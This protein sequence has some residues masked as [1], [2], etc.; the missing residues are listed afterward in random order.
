MAIVTGKG[1]RWRVWAAHAGL[2]ILLALTLF[3][4]LAVVSI[5][6]RP[7]NFATGSLI[8]AT[9]NKA[10]IVATLIEFHSHSKTGKGGCFTVPSGAV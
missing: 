8:P 1:Q 9:I 3:P 5:S 10:E 2:W 4:L 7:G 6:L